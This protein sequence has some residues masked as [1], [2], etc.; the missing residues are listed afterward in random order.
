MSEESRDAD[1]S[2]AKR[3]FL[4]LMGKWTEYELERRQREREL[5]E[6]TQH[7]SALVETT[8]ECIKTVA[9][10]GTLL[11]MNSAGLR[12]VE[13]D[14]DSDVVGESV[15]DLIASED[16]QRFRDFNERICEGERGTLEFDIVG[17]DGTRRHMESHAAPLRRPDGTTVQVALTRDITKQKER[18]RELERV[19]RQFEAAFNNPS[20]FVALL[21][22]DG[23]VRR[24]NQTALEFAGIDES[25][26]QGER[27]WETP[28]FVHDE[29]LQD[30][31]RAGI[32]RAADGEYVRSEIPH[33]SPDGET[34]IMD[35]MLEPVY[36]EDGEVVA[37]MPSGNDIT[38]RKEHEERLEQ[39]NE[40]LESFA[41]MLAHELRN[42]VTVGQ[43][44]SQ[45]LREETD[46]EAVE[47]VS[48]AF[49]R[50]EDMIDVILV[51]TRGREAVGES[52]PIDF[53]EV[54]REAWDEIDAPDAAL[55]L[56]LERTIEG[57][58]TYLRHMVRNLL[59]NA[60][61]HGG[62]D[63]TVT[64]GEL[65]SGFYVADD[66]PG[67]PPE[68]RNTVFDQGYTTAADSGGTGLG[69]AFVRKLADVYE[70]D[71][72][73]TESESGGAR[74]EFRNVR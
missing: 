48:E 31:L 2:Q 24:I 62:S 63:V 8:P 56:E 52:K 36:D 38:G 67:I 21:D 9:A 5:R 72:T 65:P 15:Y 32:E 35:A 25:D 58:E 41:S 33:R 26:V 23:T 46:P 43:I 73:V 20:S 61:E 34:V 4:D 53:A 74:F 29:E 70:W 14:S 69:L 44:Y 28:W 60:V 30:E 27:F 51:L 45:Q 18:K 66:G 10:D 3:T 54:T 11:Q 68:D 16:R 12:M 17:L 6:R 49:D 47:Y 22:P 40:R 71:I 1:F 13:A 19:E 55:D 42:P 64:V 7:L 37:I 57:E 59:E 39:Q 50:I